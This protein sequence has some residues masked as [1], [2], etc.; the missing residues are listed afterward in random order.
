[1]TVGGME[2]RRL[3][4]ELSEA[5]AQGLL[6][7]RTFEG[8]IAVL[9]GSRAVDPTALVGDLFARRRRRA[10]AIWGSLNAVW[11]RWVA[12]RS[13]PAGPLFVVALDGMASGDRLLIGRDRD[14]DVRAT[15]PT[16]SRRHAELLCRDGGWIVRDLNS[17]NGTLLN[18]QRVGR[19]RVQAGDELRLGLQRVVLD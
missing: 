15:E 12:G 6:S 14:C 3:A 2:R 9:Y 16:V 1:M 13:A 7:T 4:S 11:T 8:R 17:M 10:I 19:A 5:F 18:G